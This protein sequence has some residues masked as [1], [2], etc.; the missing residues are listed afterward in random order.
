MTDKQWQT[1][2]HAR[3]SFRTSYIIVAFNWRPPPPT[4]PSPCAQLHMLSLQFLC[5]EIGVQFSRARQI[6][7]KHFW[8]L[9]S[10]H[11]CAR[12]RHA[13]KRTHIATLTQVSQCEKW[14]IILDS[15]KISILRRRHYHHATLL[16]ISQL[17]EEQCSDCRLHSNTAHQFHCI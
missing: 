5:R 3:Y 1:R 10:F 8:L 15:N 17:Y 14:Q 2:R 12:N 11:S 13:A 4:L 6:A 7:Y 16:T 9:F